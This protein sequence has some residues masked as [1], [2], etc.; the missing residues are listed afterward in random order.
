LPDSRS[1]FT[2]SQNL[3][4]PKKAI[5]LDL[6]NTIYPVSAIGEKLFSVLFSMILESGE[7]TGD[8]EKLKAEIMRRPF[9]F[10]ADEF[11]FSEKLKTAG[12]QHLSVRTYDDEMHPY[13][14]YNLIRTL[15]CVRFLVT[16]GFSKMQSSKI[17]R[18]GIRNDFE[19]IFVIDPVQS[20]FTKKDIFLQILSK[21]N[22]LT[23]DVL[24]VGDDVNSEIQAAEELGIDAV[25]FEYQCESIQTGNHRIIGDFAQLRQFI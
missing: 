23:S 2:S 21:Y 7:F 19:E 15:P 18:L 12:I 20:I 5:I 13:E 24:V 6:D 14:N 16:T 8:F 9:Q 3:S 17:D 22:Y 11:Q 25:V 10:V 4:M 1:F